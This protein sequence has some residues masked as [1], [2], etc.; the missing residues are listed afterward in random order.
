MQVCP[1][2]NPPSRFLGDVVRT[3]ERVGSKQATWDVFPD[4]AKNET[5]ADVRLTDTDKAMQFLHMMRPLF[6]KM[7]VMGTHVPFEDMQLSS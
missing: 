4:P 2:V 3:F 6:D 7:M 5:A 1:I